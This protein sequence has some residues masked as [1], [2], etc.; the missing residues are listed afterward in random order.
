MPKGLPMTHMLVEQPVYDD[1]PDALGLHEVP[2]GLNRFA[3][4]VF[5]AIFFEDDVEAFDLGIAGG[6][7]ADFDNGSMGATVVHIQGQRI[8]RMRPGGWYGPGQKRRH[9]LVRR[10]LIIGP[11][12]RRGRTVDDLNAQVTRM[13][14]DIIEI[15]YH[16]LNRLNPIGRP[17]FVPHVNCDK[18]RLIRRS[19]SRCIDR[20]PI[21]HATVV[22]GQMLR[23]QGQVENTLVGWGCLCFGGNR[24]RDAIVL[25]VE[26]T[27][28][29]FLTLH[30]RTGVR[31][32]KEGLW[33]KPVGVKH[34]VQ[35]MQALGKR[36]LSA[37]LR[38]R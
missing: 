12:G 8:F 13:T 17:V 3:D 21:K 31:D 35:A 2:H 30:A 5:D 38:F 23:A 15:R 27:R 37:G 22:F 25:V 29:Q 18:N 32:F 28:S 33:R 1:V 9:V 6:P 16:F 14:D 20:L 4:A 11:H 26:H 7:G 24:R 10:V 34:H 36:N 19:L